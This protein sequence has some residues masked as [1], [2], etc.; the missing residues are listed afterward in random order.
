MVNKHIKPCSILLVIRETQNKTTMRHYCTPGR[1]AKMK[2]KQ[3]ISK[4][5]ND[6][7]LEEIGMNTV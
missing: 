6:V 7:E 5:N 3:T 1:M 2:K 4:V